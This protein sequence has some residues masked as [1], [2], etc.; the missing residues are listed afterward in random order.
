MSQEDVE[1]VSAAIKTWLRGDAPAALEFMAETVV[2][3]QPP[4]QADAQTY[5][6]HEGIMQAMA[7]WGGQWD[8]WRIELRRV[9][10][11]HPNVV[12]P[13]S[14]FRPGFGHFRPTSGLLPTCGILRGRCRRR[15]W[16]S[17]A[18][19]ICSFLR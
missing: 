14:D 6:G 16:S 1:V 11:A 10:D 2:T 8:D 15:M 4:T 5:V 9:I 18:P 3:T 12:A 13:T 19:G 7:D 17:F